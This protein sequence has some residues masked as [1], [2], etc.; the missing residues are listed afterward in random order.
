M[1]LSIPSA[2]RTRLLAELGQANLVF[3][4]IYP[5]DRPDRQPVHTVYGGADLFRADT[6][7]R[8]GESAMKAL[9]EHAPDFAEFARAIELPG[10]ARLPR[11][12]AETKRLAARLA[13]STEA[14][15]R[16]SPAWLAYAT[17]EKVIAKLRSE[18][19]EDFRIDFEDG[20][21]NRSADEEDSTAVSAAREVA[22]GMAA[23]S[24]PPFIGI[25]IKPFTEDLKDRGLRTLDLFLTALAAE[26][27]GKL[28]AN[29]VVMLPKVTIPEQVAALVSAFEAIES[30]SPIAP[31]SLQME[32]MVETTQA[33]LDRDGRNPLRTF[34]LASRGRMRAT[35]FGTYDYTAAC[36][37][38]ARYQDMGHSVCDF[39]H[40]VMKV[41]LGATG[42][43]LSDGATNVMPIGPHRGARLTPAQRR[44]NRTVVQRGW[45]KAYDHTRH[46][47]WKGLYQ[48][49]DL[50]PAQLPM[51][52]AA[53]YS[54]FLESRDEAT[55]RLRAFVQRAARAT[56]TDDIFDDAA[57][58]QGLLNYFLR[59]LN[60]GALS[61]DEVLATGL[62][63]EEL[64]SRSFLRILEARRQRG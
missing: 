6:A 36:N 54:F 35:A 61:E 30:H 50:N 13:R 55:E 34:V 45:K 41:A 58:G 5:G 21:G 60:C 38:T 8:M 22:K 52:Y 9:I 24:L 39:A 64:R 3:Q 63:L 15:R 25:R 42:I 29:F 32:M 16:A 28:P 37:I 51:R 46:S 48:G 49:W 62:S 4:Q 43:W 56:L 23:G 2:D 7:K 31:G 10:H 44:E 1:T 19:V 26:T 33:V 18:A 17:Y 27:G 53:V 40:H 59:G 20:F 14:A 57:T 47:L 11:A 12:A